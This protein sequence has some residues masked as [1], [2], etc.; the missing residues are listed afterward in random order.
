M[1]MISCMV[2]VCISSTCLAGWFLTL[3]V[4]KKELSDTFM[5]RAITGNYSVFLHASV[6]SKDNLF[7][8]NSFCE[9]C[10]VRYSPCRNLR[11]A[12]VC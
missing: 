3:H 4:F 1:I 10:A 11:P 12:R 5:M 8:N 6:T 2:S 9:T 7:Q